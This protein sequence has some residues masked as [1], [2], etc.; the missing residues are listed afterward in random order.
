M[1]NK[2]VLIL[3]HTHFNIK[4]IFHNFTVFTAFFILMYKYNFIKSY[5]LQTFEQYACVL[6]LSLM[7]YCVISLTTR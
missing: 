5:Q 1:N 7:E 6:L 3:N 2:I 4:N